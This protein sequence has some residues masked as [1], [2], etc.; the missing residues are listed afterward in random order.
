[1]T[2]SFHPKKVIHVYYFFVCI[3]YVVIYFPP[4]CNLQESRQGLLS[5]LF[6][7]VPQHLT[8]YLGSSH[9][10]T[11]VTNLT[12]IIE[13]ASSILSLAS[14]SGLRIWYCCG[15]KQWLIGCR[16]GSDPVFLWLEKNCIWLI[17][18]AIHSITQQS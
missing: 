4:E 3:L 12:S 16:C 10:G 6:M 7:V 1:M 9:C 18:C 17:I 5:V 8:L 14:L 11:V 15:M 13:D 2:T